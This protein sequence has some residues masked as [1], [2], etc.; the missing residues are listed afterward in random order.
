M[1]V[2]NRVLLLFLAP[3][4]LLAPA[5]SLIAQDNASGASSATNQRVSAQLGDPGRTAADHFRR[6]PI[7]SRIRHSSGAMSDTYTESVLYSFT[8]ST[9]NGCGA[10]TAPLILDAQGNLYGTT[11]YNNPYNGGTVFRLDE[12]GSN[13]TVIHTFTGDYGPNA[14]LVLDGEGNLYGT[15]VSDGGCENGTVFKMDTSG[16]NYTVLHCFTGTGGDGASPEAALT[17]DGEGHLYGTTEEGGAGCGSFGCGTVFKIDTSGNNY[18]VLYRFTGSE[19][20]D[21][22]WGRLVLDAQ[23]NLYGTTTAGFGALGCGAQGNLY[24]GTVFKLDTQGNESVLHYFTGTNGDGAYPFAGLALDAPATLYGTTANGG[25]AGCGNYGCGTAFTVDTS[26]NNYAVLYSFTGAGDGAWP[27]GDLLLDIHGMLY[28]TANYGGA[29]PAY[30]G[31]VFMLNPTT[32][33]LTVLYAFTGTNGDGAA[34]WAGVIMDGQ[35]N[36]Y[37]T[38]QYGGAYGLG[39]VYTLSSGLYTLTVAKSGTGSGTVTSTD[40]FINCGQVCSYNYGSGTQVTLMATASQDSTFTGWS[41]CDSDSGNTCTVT[42]NA[43]RTVTATFTQ[44]T[45]TLNVAIPSGGGRVVSTDGFINCPGRCRHSYPYGAFITLIATPNQGWTFTGWSGFCRGRGYCNVTMDQNLMVTANF[46]QYSS[47]LSVSVPSGGGRVTSTDG[48]INCPGTCSHW[49]PFNTHVILDARPN[50]GWT[51]VGWGGACSGTGS[52]QVN[53]TQNLS[54]IGAFSQ[55]QNNDILLVS[56]PGGGGIVTSADGFIN[57]PGSCEHAY[58][59]HAQVSL[60]VRPNPGWR[61]SSW[62][63]ACTGTGFCRIDMTQNRSVTAIFTPP[64]CDNGFCPEHFSHAAQ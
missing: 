46:A 48:F 23:G 61:F 39:A 11:I 33:D 40:G 49:Y 21:D 31:T 5:V 35:G 44:N 57:C 34:P 43:N 63:G 3:V 26:G 25:I 30:W 14:G 28:G 19:G 55:N 4:I 20:D 7:V 12:N 8:P 45:Y 42:V 56:I 27:Y 41:G 18:A 6:G 53:M 54:V 64:P 59:P 29:P 24:C 58:P 32:D 17:L 1:D 9:G 36:L 16:N 38:T 2:S 13:Y 50:Q 22:P 10:T 15:T 62:E 47:M 52:C 37:G 51:F 60:Y